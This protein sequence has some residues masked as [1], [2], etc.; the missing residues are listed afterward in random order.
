MTLSYFIE[1]NPG[2]RGMLGQHTYASHRLR[3]A[4]KGPYETTRQFE[5]RI[6]QAA[7]AEDDA[8]TAIRPFDSDP[9]WLV[10]PTNRVRG[11]LPADIWRGTAR[12]LADCGVLAVYPAG[13]WWKYNNSADRVGRPATYGLLVSLTT[14]EITADL[15]TPTAIQLG[16]PV[17]TEITSAV[18]T[19]I[20]SRLF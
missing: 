13:G 11:C 18:E 15:Y 10:G 14:P 20:D 6:A 19:S 9:N 8:R 12:E 7:Q 4:L 5:G 2:R 1:P 17:P 3:F 16:V